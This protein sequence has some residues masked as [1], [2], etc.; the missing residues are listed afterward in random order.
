MTDTILFEELLEESQGIYGLNEASFSIIPRFK[1][2]PKTKPL[3]DTLIKSEALLRSNDIVDQKSFI[4]NKDAFDDTYNKV[5]DIYL[6][7]LN[8]V[9]SISLA[10]ISPLTGLAFFVG[11][12]LFDRLS[13]YAVDSI[14]EKYL[15]KSAGNAIKHL[16]DLSKKLSGKEKEKVLKNKKELEERL[17]KLESKGGKKNS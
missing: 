3:A 9:S 13:K 15:K 10:L 6:L 7:V 5:L 17:A 1:A 14:N 8:G 2:D 4:A 12:H 11:V 16:D